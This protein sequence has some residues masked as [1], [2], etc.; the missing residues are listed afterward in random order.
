MS[1]PETPSSGTD[2]CASQRHSGWMPAAPPAAAPV[3]R[4]Q[5]TIAHLR[6]GRPGTPG[7][8]QGGGHGRPGAAGRRLGLLGGFTAHTAPAGAPSPHGPGA[9][10]SPP[11]RPPRR[12][13]R[14]HRTASRPSGRGRPGP[15]PPHGSLRLPPLPPSPGP[16]G[17]HREAAAAPRTHREEAVAALGPDC[18]GALIAGGG[19]GKDPPRT[20]RT[21]R[22]ERL[23]GTRRRRSRT[24]KTDSGAAF[25]G[26]RAGG[27]AERSRRRR[28]CPWR[29][30]QAAA[31]PRQQPHN[32]RRAGPRPAGWGDA[33]ARPRRR[34]GERALRGTGRSWGQSGAPGTA[35]GARVRGWQVV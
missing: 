16:L 1:K 23:S 33:R 17:P 22:R 5:V 14:H 21:A 13:P 20:A 18:G 9:L 7:Q 27:G 25:R 28:S 8:G 34:E 29:V 2:S 15:P 6:R 35:E 32:R 19:G 24:A 4:S 31:G 30:L 11:A 12:G 10:I 3:T 26:V